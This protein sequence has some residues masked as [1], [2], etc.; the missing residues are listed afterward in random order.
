MLYMILHSLSDRPTGIYSSSS[1]L[2]LKQTF[3]DGYTPESVICE[4]ALD[5]TFMACFLIIVPDNKWFSFSFFILP[6]IFFLC[7]ADGG[8]VEL[9]PFVSRPRAPTF[10]R[11]H[12]GG[13]TQRFAAEEDRPVGPRKGKTSDQTGLINV[14]GL[15][16]TT[17]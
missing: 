6:C 15:K 12:W 16:I 5:V 14:A 2:K 1:E 8:E 7:S 17:Q 11:G 9:L 10:L 13:A 3:L 4:L